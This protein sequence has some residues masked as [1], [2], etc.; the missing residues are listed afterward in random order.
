MKKIIIA[1]ALLVNAS[2]LFAQNSV[3]SQARSEHY[4]VLSEIGQTNA[5]SMAKQLEALFNLFNGYFRFDPATLKGPLTVRI[6]KDK[7]TFDSY[8]DKIVKETKSDFVYLHYPTIERSELVV[9]Q[10]TKTE[11]DY[12]LAHQSFVQFLKAFIPNPPL[13]IRD[14]FAIFFEKASW[15]AATEKL[16]F[17]RNDDWLEHVKIINQEGKLVGAKALMNMTSVEATTNNAVLYPQ[18]WA[19]VAFC[20][21][22]S[23]KKYNRFIWDAIN[24]LKR[25][26][27]AE[28]NQTTI[29]KLFDSWYTEENMRSDFI[30]WLDG[31]KTFS[32]MITDGVKAYGEKSYEASEQEFTK[33]LSINK[34]NYI[35]YYYLGLISYAKN[36]FAAAD[37]YYKTALQLGCDIAITNYALGLN[38]YASNR[39]AEAKTYLNI[40]KETAADKYGTRVDEI[41]SKINSNQ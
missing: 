15:N 21:D 29:N 16:D 19:F 20:I 7:T 23:D 5:D 35:P 30:A 12:A 8:L 39:F 3:F 36:D 22:G 14:G 37:F 17:T 38:A 26:A 40:A 1:V 32:E 9:F 28:E 13:W 25:E 34:D 11:F 27:T 10:K 6:F 18:S 2:L 24:E 41:L 31:R 4:T 33:A